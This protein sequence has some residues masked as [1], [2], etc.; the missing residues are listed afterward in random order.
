MCCL[1]Y[2]YMYVSRLYCVISE[3]RLGAIFRGKTKVAVTSDSFYF[4]RL[5]SFCEQMNLQETLLNNS[6]I[7]HLH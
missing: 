1:V 4:S 2:N 5:G 3:F 7:Y 6:L